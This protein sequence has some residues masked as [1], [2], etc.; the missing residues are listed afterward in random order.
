MTHVIVAS[1]SWYKELPEKL[2]SL[3]GEKFVW[4]ENKK[5]LTLERLQ[6]LQP[7]YVFFPHWSYIIPAEIYENFACVIFHMTDV[8]FGRGGS[9]LQNLIARGIYETKISALKC[10]AGLDSGPVYMKRPLYLYGAAEEIYLRAAKIITEMIVSIVKD[11]P[12]PVEQK[13]DVVCFARRKPAEGNI[14]DLAELGQIYDYI[15]MLDAAGY[16]RA[17]LETEHFRF[18]FERA[19][20]KHGYITADVKI[21]PKKGKSERNEK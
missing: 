16:P 11:K 8:P 6:S 1:R 10:Q 9:P 4:I 15:R 2:A 12:I 5:D 19:S 3:T 20:L 21:I 14:A 13:G 17:F 7:E 18:E